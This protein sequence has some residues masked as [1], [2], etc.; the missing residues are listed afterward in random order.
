[1]FSISD[2][3]GCFIGGTVFYTR[4]ARQEM[5]NDEYGRIY[6]HEVD[7]A[8]TRGEI[9]EQYPGDKPYS[10]ALIFGETFSGRPVHV[11][12]AHDEVENIAIVIT[13]YQPDPLLWMDYKRR[14]K[15]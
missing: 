2:I 8:V 9:I 14:I 1:M 11:V 13:V 3:R 15:I 6:E 10:S 5:E 12:C 7:E 4:H